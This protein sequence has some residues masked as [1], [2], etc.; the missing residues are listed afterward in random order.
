MLE[1]FSVISLF[2]ERKNKEKQL[3][4]FKNKKY[5]SKNQLYHNK[6]ALSYVI[7]A[8]LISFGNYLHLKFTINFIQDFPW[9]K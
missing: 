2:H 1:S 7:I 8:S 6:E 3:E 9:N 5:F 4:D